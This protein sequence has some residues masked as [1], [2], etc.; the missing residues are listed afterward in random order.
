[1]THVIIFNGPPGSGKDEA[2]SYL[3]CQHGFKHLSFKYQLFIEAIKYYNVSKE[4]FMFGYQD[5]NTKEQPE[6]L[7]NGKSRREALIHVSEDIIKP[8]YGKGF[9]GKQAAKQINSVNDYCFSDG[10]FIEELQEIINTIGAK[11]V[12]VIQLLRDGCSFK[13]D[14]RRY[15]NGLIFDEHILGHSTQINQSYIM[16]ESL[17]VRIRRVHNNGTLSEFYKLLAAIYFEER[18]AKKRTNISRKPF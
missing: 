13:N 12:T 15:F 9:F 14:S 17:D 10:G 3:T 5:R 18:D 7:L 4:W 1:M 11:N 8:K 16:P 2:C 6:V